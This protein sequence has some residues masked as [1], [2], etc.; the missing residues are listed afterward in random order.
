MPVLFLNPSISNTP[1]SMQKTETVL[2][3]IMKETAPQGALCN[4]RRNLNL[5][6]DNIEPTTENKNSSL[7]MWSLIGQK[8][9]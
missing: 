5:F 9:T 8:M 1:N 4:L 3:L 7:K 6:L 2:F